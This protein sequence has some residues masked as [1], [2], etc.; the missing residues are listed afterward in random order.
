MGLLWQLIKCYLMV[1]GCCS[2]QIFSEPQEH[3]PEITFNKETYEIGEIL[4]AN[5]TTASS[6]PPPHITWFINDQKVSSFVLF[7]G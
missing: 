5:C 6:R 4:E 1:D 3:D 2:S 7:N